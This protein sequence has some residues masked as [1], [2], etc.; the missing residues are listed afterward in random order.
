MAGGDHGRL[1][2]GPDPILEERFTLLVAALTLMIFAPVAILAPSFRR[3]TIGLALATTFVFG[4]G[5][6]YLAS[7]QQ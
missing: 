5:I 2:A 7:W 3:G 4:W 1:G 6:P